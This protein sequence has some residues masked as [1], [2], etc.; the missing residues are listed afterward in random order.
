MNYKE[1]FTKELQ[2][3]LQKDLDIKN[4]MA[5]PK[6]VKIVINVGIGTYTK[7]HKDFSNVVE[8]VSNITGQK[9]VI[10]KSRM[11]I[12]NFKLRQDMPVGVMTTLRGKRMYDFMHKLVH[13]IFPRIRD[14]RG[15]STKSFD[16]H[17]NY[18]VGITDF[19]IF[20]EINLDDI[21]HDHGLQISIITSAK[22]DQE[23]EMLLK[24][25]G[26]PFK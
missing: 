3:A 19:T 17:G 10:R 24:S 18:S 14:F 20:P 15:F 1:T 21:V 13:V 7:Q 22:N 11:A 4:V 25:F 16:G 9:P 2:P 5:T 12:S 6:L 23:G 26:F 8:N